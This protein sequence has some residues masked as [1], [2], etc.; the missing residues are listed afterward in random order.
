M[1]LACL[2]L[3]LYALAGRSSPRP[4]LTPVAVSPARHSENTR[5]K[6][7]DDAVAKAQLHVLDEV[8]WNVFGTTPEGSSTSGGTEVLKAAALVLCRDGYGPVGA[9]KAFGPEVSERVCSDE[10]AAGGMKSLSGLADHGD[11]NA[12]TALA[13]IYNAGARGVQ[14]NA[15]ESLKWARLA[16]RARLPAGQRIVGDHYL[17]GESLPKDDRVALEW[18]RRASVQG[19]LRSQDTLCRQYH[20]KS[21]DPSSL[22]SFYGRSQLAPPLRS[23]ILAYAWCSLAASN[24]TGGEDAAEV[25]RR[26]GRERDRV[27]ETLSAHQLATAQGRV[28]EWRMKYPGLHRP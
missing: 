4:Y 7:I 2:G 9:L 18:Y 20:E 8:A 17:G 5:E 23:D 27:A 11:L 14:R 19:D 24:P 15:L 3:G 1:T 25:R 28:R 12:A 16:A 26:A 13:Y 6:E 10:K 21:P 22:E